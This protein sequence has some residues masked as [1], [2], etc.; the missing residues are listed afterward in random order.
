M[1]MIRFTGEGRGAQPLSAAQGQ[2]RQRRPNDRAG[3]SWRTN[4]KPSECHII[5]RQRGDS[6]P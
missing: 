6:A 1:Q 4:C 3:T 2:H 5:G